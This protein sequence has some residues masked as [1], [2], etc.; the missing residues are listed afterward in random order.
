MLSKL[1]PLLS[2][3][4]N[5]VQ[6]PRIVLLASTSQGRKDL[7]GRMGLPVQLT[8]SSFPED[9]DKDM[10]PIDYVLQT[11]SGKAYSVMNTLLSQSEVSDSEKAEKS[12]ND[13]PDMIIAADTMVTL[14][15]E[16][17]PTRG[18][19]LVEDKYKIIGKPDSNEDAINTLLL[20]KGKRHFITTG[21]SLLLPLSPINTSKSDD[22]LTS[23]TN[24]EN[25]L[26]KC[27]FKY[28]QTTLL[29][30]K[31]YTNQSHSSLDPVVSVE[32][33]T[34]TKLEQFLN[35][36]PPNSHSNSLKSKPH[37]INTTH[38]H[39]NESKWYHIQFTSTSSVEFDDVDIETIKSYVSTG[40][41]LGKAGSYAIQG[42][43]GSLI[44]GMSG[45]YQNI[46]GFPSNKFGHLVSLL[47][48]NTTDDPSPVIWTSKQ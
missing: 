22:I 16:R 27:L 14:H 25:W 18:S 35:Q 19:D 9:L 34:D 1:T 48:F 31:K 10:H 23:E 29:S 20:L 21:V 32:I 6:P 33:L 41:P 11:A 38:S 4:P 24:L 45:C 26:Q 12:T 17:Y 30:D 40:E 3:G 5:G 28:D 13:F 46:V 47:F 39:C 43:G 36:Y 42:V 2:P 15:H 7:F 8:G 44:K 37:P